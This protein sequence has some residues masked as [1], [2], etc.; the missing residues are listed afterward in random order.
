MSLFPS[1]PDVFVDRTG[2]DVIASS[3]PNNAY[4]AI[5]NIENFL[6]ASG[7][8]QSKSV[9]MVNLFRAMLNPIPA[10]S[11][12]N[13]SSVGIPAYQFALFNGDNFVFKRNATVTTCSLAAH[14]LNGSEAATTWYEVY[15]VGDGSNSAFTMGLL[16]QGTDP[17]A[18]A[19][20][21]QKIGAIRNDGSSDLLK[22]Y[23]QGAQVMWDVP[24]GIS[25]A[26]S[27]AGWSAALSCTVGMPSMSELA[28]FGLSA[29]NN[30]GGEFAGIWI[31]P[32]GSAMGTNFANG[33]VNDGGD[34]AGISGQRM[35]MTDDAQQIQFTNVDNTGG[36]ETISITVEGY[37]VNI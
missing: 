37:I 12:V 22:F 9:T 10:L 7:Q 28:I 17:S 35:C 23:Q 11:Y 19:T 32:N 26:S 8:P 29:F 25:S 20:Y 18:Y 3:D 6:G 16:G 31:R 5:E 15:I 34:P 30:S 24:V 14:L 4:D 27:P 13:A 2:S 36:G 1:A 21:Y 33:I